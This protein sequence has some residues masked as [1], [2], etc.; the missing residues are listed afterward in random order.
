MH[1]ANTFDF[2]LGVETIVSE[3]LR[4]KVLS[5]LFLS[6]SLVFLLLTTLLPGDYDAV[7]GVGAT[8]YQLAALLFGMS[9][10]EFA[11]N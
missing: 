7:F 11:L 2:Q 1:D 5:I 3:K 9:A 10:Y 6:A 4:A 8:R